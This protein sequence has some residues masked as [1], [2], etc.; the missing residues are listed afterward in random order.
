MRLSCKGVAVTGDPF[1]Y[2]KGYGIFKLERINRK[3]VIRKILNRII[4]KFR[5]Y[6]NEERKK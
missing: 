2:I 3:R 5:D 4:R 1:F 6:K